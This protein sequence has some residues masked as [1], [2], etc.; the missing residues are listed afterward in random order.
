M[1]QLRKINEEKYS[2][3]LRDDIKKMFEGLVGCTTD[4]ISNISN[5]CTMVAYHTKGGLLNKLRDIRDGMINSIVAD[6]VRRRHTN[7]S[8]ATEIHYANVYKKLLQDTEWSVGIPIVE[9]FINNEERKM[10]D[11]FFIDL[12]EILLNVISYDRIIVHYGSKVYQTC[13]EIVSVSESH[14][15]ENKTA[16]T[17]KGY[18][19]LI[20]YTLSVSECIK[21]EDIITRQKDNSMFLKPNA[22]AIHCAIAEALALQKR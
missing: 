21:G 3:I 13:Q 16:L 4:A 2:Y 17:N 7:K 12:K 22:N 6:F 18:K 10:I 1:E 19:A 8:P 20:D 11:G 9:I 14:V 15:G 5:A